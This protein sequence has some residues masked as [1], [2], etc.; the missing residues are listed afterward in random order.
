M[1]KLDSV[2]EDRARRMVLDRSMWPMDYLPMKRLSNGPM[3]FGVIAFNEALPDR[4]VIRE[5]GGALIKIFKSI[6]ALVDANWTVD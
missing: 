1:K 6:D 5:R 4:I 2:R 3:E